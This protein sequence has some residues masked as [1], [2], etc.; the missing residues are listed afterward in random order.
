M[1]QRCIQQFHEYE[2]LNKAAALRDL[3]DFRS[4]DW[5]DD[6]DDDDDDDDTVEFAAGYSSLLSHRPVPG[7]QEQKRDFAWAQKQLLS[8]A[9]GLKTEPGVKEANH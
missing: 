8:T 9:E 4:L 5:G 7:T 6:R 3:E 2:E 1:D